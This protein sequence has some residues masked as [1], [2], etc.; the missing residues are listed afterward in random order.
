MVELFPISK[1]AWVVKFKNAKTNRTSDPEVV[2]DPQVH[3]D[4]TPLPGPSDNSGLLAPSCGQIK[5]LQGVT[6]RRAP[7]SVFPSW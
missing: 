2:R 7:A 4:W 6:V 1:K 3:I 5:L